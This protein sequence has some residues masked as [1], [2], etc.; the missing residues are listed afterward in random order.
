[1]EAVPTIWGPGQVEGPVNIPPG[2]PCWIMSFNEPNQSLPYGPGV[3]PENYA[4]YQRR[5]EERF[6]GCRIVS[7]GP[8]HDD[9]HWLERAR[10]A[11]IA[12]Y[13]T[14]PR[15]DALAMHCYLYSW[16][17]QEM[18]SQYLQWS[19]AWGVPEI[20]IT[21]FA[22]LPCRYANQDAA[23]ADA[24]VFINWTATQP[25]ITRLAWFAELIYGHEPWS[26]ATCN[27][28]LFNASLQQT[29]FGS[30][31]QRIAR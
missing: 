22:A 5:I 25:R 28:S 19:Q 27:P 26:F 10:G 13:H 14:P 18:T 20:W 24:E 21:E 12:R 3:S 11:Y 30:L 4:I 1:V 23:L 9:I 7:P 6:P 2:Q 8:S 31:Y 17:C 15:W 29:A 16:E